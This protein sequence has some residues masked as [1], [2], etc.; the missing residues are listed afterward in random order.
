M[1]YGC[2]RF[3]SKRSLSVVVR[4]LCE[5]S[6]KTA[7]ELTWSPDVHYA[8]VIVDYNAIVV[9]CNLWQYIVQCSILGQFYLDLY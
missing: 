1:L 5:Q 9:H 4:R 2:K 3:Y 7:N 6:C 8:C